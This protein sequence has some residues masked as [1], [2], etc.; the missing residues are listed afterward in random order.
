MAASAACPTFGR[1]LP[2]VPAARPTAATVA[3]LAGRACPAGGPPE[4]DPAGDNPRI[5]AGWAFFGQLLAHDLSHERRPLG[6]HPAPQPHAEPGQ[7]H[8]APRL[9][10]ESLYGLGP[11]DQPYLYEPGDPDRLLLE[12]RTDGGRT[13]WDL[14]RLADGRAVVP[15]ARDDS[16][17]PVAQLHVLLARVHNRLVTDARDRGV[18]SGDAFHT[19]RQALR[20]HVAHV[21]THEYLPLTTGRPARD[22]GAGPADG[23]AALPVEFAAGVFRFGHAQLRARYRRQRGEAPVALLPDLVGFRPLA[24]DRVLAWDRLFARP[25][26]PPPQ[27]SR[28]IGV[29]Y[30]R[31]LAALPRSL[32]G[33]LARPEHASLAW[34][35]G[36]RS[37]QCGLP[38]GAATARALGEAPLT[39]GALGLSSR[40]VERGVPLLHYVLAEAECRADG[41]HLGPVGGRLLADVLSRV[42]Q[43]PPPDWRPTLASAQPGRFGIADLIAAVGD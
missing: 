26:A 16:N 14:P 35:D 22:P 32:T 19:A 27:P 17:V 39:A 1:A 15:D 13:V 2:D 11:A 8:R 41:R 4:D 40:A 36:Q 5:S 33:P 34:R 37:A 38:C 23:L 31:P 10:L 7:T 24:P 29:R 21:V 30:A 25:G 28:T 18:A 20:W 3:A 42:V 9:D 12:P 43:A 6:A